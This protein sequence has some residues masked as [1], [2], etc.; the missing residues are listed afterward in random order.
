MEPS[1][2]QG[3]AAQSKTSRAIL[4]LESRP[5]VLNAALYDR[6]PFPHLQ[7]LQEVAFDLGITALH[8]DLELSGLVV[9]GYS[10]GQML[11]EQRWPARVIRQKINQESLEIPADTGIAVR[12]L[13]FMLHGYEL[14]THLAITAVA[15]ERITSKSLQSTLQIP[16]T[17]HQQSTDIHFPLE[18]AWWAIHGSDWSDVHKTEPYSQPFALDF[19]KLGPDNRTFRDAGSSLEDHYGWDQPVFAAAGGKVASVIYDMPDI[20]PGTVPDAHMM[21]DDPQR[22]L[23]NAVVISHGN[24]EFSYYAALQQASIQ[25]NQGEV[26]R[27]NTLIA[28]VGNSGYSPGPHLHFHLMEGPHLFIDRGIPVRFSHFSAGGQFFEQPALI[29]TRLI[30]I[31]PARDHR[32][33]KE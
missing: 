14:L 29:P 19:V 27:R 7:P 16:V 15:Q 30:A 3:Q 1:I 9:Q 18:G 28:R 5:S 4:A 25:V 32:P 22:I 13:H 11:F 31:G 21:R 10:G 2:A 20:S 24:G 6:L 17:F 12:G 23:G 26:V 33:T 8:D